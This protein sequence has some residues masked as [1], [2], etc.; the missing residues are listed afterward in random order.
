MLVAMSHMR[1]PASCRG[2]A[3]GIVDGAASEG[4][5]AF[6]ADVKGTWRCH[7]RRMADDGRTIGFTIVATLDEKG[8]NIL[9]WDYG[10]LICRGF[11]LPLHCPLL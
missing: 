2:V 5:P 4:I 1:L 7:K 3:L 10:G 6:G 11:L 9:H 8:L